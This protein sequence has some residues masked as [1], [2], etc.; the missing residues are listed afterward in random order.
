VPGGRR[1]NDGFDVITENKPGVKFTVE[2]KN[3]GMIRIP[4]G[5]PFKV[6]IH[7]PSYTFE[8]VI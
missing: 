2:Q 7:K 6:F 8:P 3:K 1:D 5:Y 4:G